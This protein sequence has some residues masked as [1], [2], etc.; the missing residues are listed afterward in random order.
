MHSWSTVRSVEMNSRNQWFMTSSSRWYEWTCKCRHT[1]YTCKIQIYKIYIHKIKSLS[2]GSF[3]SRAITI[4][5]TI[6]IT[7]YKSFSI[8]KNRRV[9]T[10]ALTI[11]AESSDIIGIT[12]RMI[13]SIWWTIQTLILN[14]NPS[15]YN[16]RK[17][18]KKQTSM[19]LEKQ[20]ISSAGESMLISSSL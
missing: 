14:Q 9:R 11:K 12:F 20:M 7:F 5:I 18:L 15:C 3:T 13:F 8:L 6:K 2:K 16:E 1:R 19:S 10:T 17:N 4:K